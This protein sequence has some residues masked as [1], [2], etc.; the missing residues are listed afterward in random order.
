M[1]LVSFRASF[2][3]APH[4]EI[5]TYMLVLAGR[6]DQMHT[7][8]CLLNR[9]VGVGRVYKICFDTFDT[10]V[11]ETLLGSCQYRCLCAGIFKE[12]WGFGMNGEA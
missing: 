11:F 8:D 10:Q 4:W 12:S 6:I 2:F 1:G 9:S 7:I 3:L 5:M